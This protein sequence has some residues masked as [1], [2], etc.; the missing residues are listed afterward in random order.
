[1]SGSDWRAV[2]RANR[3]RTEGTAPPAA[4]PA[5]PPVAPPVAHPAAPMQAAPPPPPPPPPAARP[6]GR[7]RAGAAFGG[8]ALRR[9]SAASPYGPLPSGVAAAVL[10]M[11]VVAASLALTGAGQREFYQWEWPA[12]L[13]LLLGA[14]WGIYHAREKAW[15]DRLLMVCGG[16][17]ACTILAQM[18]GALAVGF[19][20]VVV[21]TTALL[22]VVET[23]TYPLDVVEAS[24][25]GAP[26]SVPLFYLACWGLAGSVL[27][28]SW[29]FLRSRRAALG[30]LLAVGLGS[31]ATAREP[32]GVVEMSPFVNEFVPA[33]QANRFTE[34]R[35][36]AERFIAAHP[37]RFGF[38]PGE[39]AP[40]N[41]GGVRK[42]D[43]Q[44]ASYL[45]WRVWLEREAMTIAD[46][47]GTGRPVGFQGTPLLEC[48]LDW[49]VLEPPNTGAGVK[50]RIRN[51][52][53]EGAS[54]KLARQR[55]PANPAMVELFGP[56]VAAPP[57][58]A[59]QASP[60]PAPA[61]PS[62]RPAPS[63]PARN[64]SLENWRLFDMLAIGAAALLGLGWVA[65][66]RK[67]ARQ[68]V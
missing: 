66:R 15:P 34:A 27:W 51:T 50:A 54:C 67:L 7:D 31:A 13:P 9:L 32:M 37:A 64:P 44:I 29:R 30:L 58:P 45:L 53:R 47:E 22:T 6:V 28:K 25:G 21:A 4:P 59:P 57:A 36:I 26:L 17:V 24:S 43:A 39:L 20:V 10:G 1:M 8:A 42:S 63:R 49:Y 48:L 60:R 12:A 62:A 5:A 3:Q 14:G 33:F 11:V 19:G 41:F 40:E 68:G 2:S 55:F 46:A 65:R 52:I 61:P 35:R 18:A 16:V 56:A 23:F 38:D